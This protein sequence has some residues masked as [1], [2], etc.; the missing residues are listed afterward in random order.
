MPQISKD[1]F[2]KFKE[3]VEK[4]KMDKIF[5]EMNR[6]EVLEKLSDKVKALIHL[7]KSLG[8][9]EAYARTFAKLIEGDMKFHKTDVMV[10]DWADIQ[11]YLTPACL[12]FHGFN[13]GFPKYNIVYPKMIFRRRM[14]ELGYK[15][16]VDNKWNIF[17]V[18]KYIS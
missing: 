7:N 8:D 17:T 12:D 16:N 5:R 3:L 10:Y 9:I 6:D 14:K 4:E 11:R 15:M 13:A 2:K 18:R 1:E